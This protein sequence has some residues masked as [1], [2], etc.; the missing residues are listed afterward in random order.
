GGIDT[1]HAPILHRLL[2]NSSRR[3]GFKPANPFVRGKAPTLVVDLTDY[4]YQYAGIRP[5]DETSVHIRTYHFILPFHQ[6]RPSVSDNGAP[7]VAGHIGLP[8]DA[9]KTM[10]Y[11]GIWTPP[12]PLTD[13]DRLERRLGTGPLDVDQTTFRS[14][15]N[16]G[17]SYLL[18]RRVQKTES[19]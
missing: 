19:F 4:G 18:D 10:A 1:S 16:R 15:R 12:Q 7:R 8:R 6:I 13:D 17:N 9:E 14:R 5:L 3:G 11:T 2:T